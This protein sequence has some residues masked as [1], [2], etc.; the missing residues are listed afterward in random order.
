MRTG[1]NFSKAKQARKD[2]IVDQ[3]LDHKLSRALAGSLLLDLG[4]EEWEVNLY[5][6]NDQ[7]GPE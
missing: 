3:Y 7:T 6:D 4:F 1:F 2:Q 5:L